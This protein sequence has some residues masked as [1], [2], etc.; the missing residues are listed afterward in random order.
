MSDLEKR[1]TAIERAITSFRAE[2]EILHLRNDKGG[3]EA[4]DTT[5]LYRVL[6]NMVRA[7]DLDK[8]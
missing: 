2:L 3:T 7:L 1:V 8:G 5:A 4:L 6:G